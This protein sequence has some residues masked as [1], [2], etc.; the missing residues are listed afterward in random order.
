MSHE[1]LQTPY[2]YLFQYIYIYFTITSSNTSLI[3]GASICVELRLFR[4]DDTRFYPVPSRHLYIP[5]VDFVF[6][7]G[8]DHFLTFKDITIYKGCPTKS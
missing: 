6:C 3:T 1:S 2:L 8:S 7:T 5:I 4:K